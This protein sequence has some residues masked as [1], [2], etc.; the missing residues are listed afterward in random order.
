MDEALLGGWGGGG[1]GHLHVGL[2]SEFQIRLF[3]ILRSTYSMSLM[4]F[5]QS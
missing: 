1:V 4:V 5:N 2:Q 3:C